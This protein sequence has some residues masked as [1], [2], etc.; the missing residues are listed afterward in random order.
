MLEI[1]CHGSFDSYNI[2]QVA[3]LESESKNV[4]VAILT[5]QMLF[6]CYCNEERAANTRQYISQQMKKMFVFKESQCGIAHEC[7]FDVL[8]IQVLLNSFFQVTM[9]IL[10]FVI[11]QNKA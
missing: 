11:A 4:R 2:L 1:T 7:R 8:S 10:R 6:T 9:G 3:V 5:R